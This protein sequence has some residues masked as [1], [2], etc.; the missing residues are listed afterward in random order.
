MAV[1]GSYLAKP[2]PLAGRMTEFADN[3]DSDDFGIGELWLLGFPWQ[4]ATTV[5]LDHPC[6][7]QEKDDVEEVFTTEV[8]G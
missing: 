1:R 7:Y 2:S 4:V 6:V 3:Q 5:G 8:V